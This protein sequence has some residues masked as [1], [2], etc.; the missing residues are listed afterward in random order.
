[1]LKSDGYTM[2]SAHSTVKLSECGD[3]GAVAEPAASYV[4]SEVPF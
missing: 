2:D 1:M 4:Q 3:S